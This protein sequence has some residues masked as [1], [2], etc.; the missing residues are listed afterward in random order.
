MRFRT[1][2]V[3]EIFNGLGIPRVPPVDYPPRSTSDLFAISIAAMGVGM[4][5]FLET[6]CLGNAQAQDNYAKLGVQPNENEAG[7]GG[8]SS[9]Q[10]S[11]TKKN[12]N[13]EKPRGYPPQWSNAEA[14]VERT[15]AQ[16]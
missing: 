9:I 15:T 12:I 11:A 1:R 13:C 10:R 14:N 7:R 8:T 2:S 16:E 5:K 6:F 3:A 4:R